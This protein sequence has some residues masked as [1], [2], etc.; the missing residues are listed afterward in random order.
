MIENVLTGEGTYSD[1]ILVAP[2]HYLMAEITEE[3]SN[4]VATLSVQRI[5]D[6]SDPAQPNDADSRWVT[7]ESLETGADPVSNVKHSGLAWYR[8]A[9]LA[10]DY[11]SGSARVKLTTCP[12]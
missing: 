4:L 3:T 2:D 1:P 5:L 12:K 11:T 10:G 6:A 7:I 8:I 9:I